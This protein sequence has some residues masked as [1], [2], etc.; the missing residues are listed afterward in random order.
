[1]RLEYTHEGPRGRTLIE[2]IR[3]K[4][5]VEYANWMDDTEAGDL[6][7]GRVEGMCAALG[8]LCSTNELLQWESVEARYKDRERL[9]AAN[10]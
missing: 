9:A 3:D 1:M 6:E 8:I 5:D 2:R 7:I 10:D 4:A